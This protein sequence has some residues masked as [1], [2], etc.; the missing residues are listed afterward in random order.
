MIRCPSA[1]V[2][3][4]GYMFTAGENA[5]RRNCQ[6]GGEQKGDEED[7]KWISWLISSIMAAFS[8]IT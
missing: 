8:L 2:A 4:A 7:A 3:L 6:D 1:L 5:R